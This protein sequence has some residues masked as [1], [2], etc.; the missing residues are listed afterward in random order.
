MA[1]GLSET[2][3]FDFRVANLAV[4]LRDGVRLTRLVEVVTG[5]WGLAMGLRVPAVSRLQVKIFVFFTS[6]TPCKLSYR[7]RRWVCSLGRRSGWG[8][9]GMEVRG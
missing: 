9:G 6:A 3:E 4:D 7:C 2:D 1:D 5:E 8:V